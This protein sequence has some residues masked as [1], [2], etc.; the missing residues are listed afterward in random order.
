LVAFGVLFERIFVYKRR[1]FLGEHN[2]QIRFVQISTNASF[3]FTLFICTA[4]RVL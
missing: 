2:L 4:E 3:V 1:E